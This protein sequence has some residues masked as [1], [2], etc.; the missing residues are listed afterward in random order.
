MFHRILFTRIENSY[1]DSSRNFQYKNLNSPPFSFNPPLKNRNLHEEESILC[2]WRADWPAYLVHSRLKTRPL[3]AEIDCRVHVSHPLSEGMASLE[4]EEERIDQSPFLFFF[5]IASCT[6]AHD[7]RF[8]ID[9]H[10]S[11]ITRR[12]MLLC[13]RGIARSITIANFIVL[14]LQ[15]LFCWL[16]Y[17]PCVA[18]VGRSCYLSCTLC[19]CCNT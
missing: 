6:N 2:L 17:W 14:Y 12:R 3:H 16:V 13:L 8:P 11:L 1:H 4:M 5:T 9:R 19:G 10:E 15:W 18:I 7:T